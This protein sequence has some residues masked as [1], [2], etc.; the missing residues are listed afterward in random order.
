MERRGPWV[1]L[2]VIG[3]LDLGTADR[4]RDAAERATERSDEFLALDLSGVGFID[5]SGLRSLL[6]LRHH[7]G[8]PTLVA[9]NESVRTLL[10]L[11]LMT[12]AFPIVDGIADLEG[13]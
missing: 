1:V 2:T 9:P 5:S 6:E 8:G 3:D 4:V 13:A 12:D 11:T 7:R 10:D